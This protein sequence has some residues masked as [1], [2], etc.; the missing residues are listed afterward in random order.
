MKS[1]QFAEKT[2]NYVAALDS[3]SRAFEA[4]SDDG[5]GY[6]LATYMVSIYAML[7]RF[8]EADAMLKR[9]A[10]INEKME[11][12]E[13][14]IWDRMYFTSYRYFADG[15]KA[16]ANER[17]DEVFRMVDPSTLDTLAREYTTRGYA[18]A[19]VGRIDEAKEVLK[20]QARYVPASW[21]VE[22]DAVHLTEGMIA[23]HDGQYD[24]AIEDIKWVRANMNTIPRVLELELA[25]AMVAANRL[26]EA[27]PVLESAARGK[28]W[29]GLLND[30]GAS[31]LSFRLLGETY[32]RM[33]QTEQA[34]EAYEMFVERWQ[35]A[36]AVLQPQVK[37][38]QDRIAT[39]LDRQSTDQ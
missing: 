20:E 2:G 37:E 38:V 31:S 18:L 29:A 13:G 11:N 9:S 21:L 36:D 27:I 28:G 26:E 25:M 34:I 12:R 8:E 10:E 4:Y 24:K 1:A 15:D 7:G 17:I 5:E 23:L 30:F 19:A 32:D 16:L 22:D 3:F 39:L 35:H 6:F 33:G 14:I